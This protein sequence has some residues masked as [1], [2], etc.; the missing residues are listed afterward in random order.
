MIFWFSGTGNALRAASELARCTGDRTV[1]M[2]EAVHAGEFT[3]TLGAG[4]PLGIVVPVY[5]WGIPAMAHTFLSQLRFS[6]GEKP[7]YV[8]SVIVCGCCWLIVVMY[9]LFYL[10]VV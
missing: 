4:E 2:A 10:V 8:F 1:S 9:L 5:Y 6:D 7:C 3:Y